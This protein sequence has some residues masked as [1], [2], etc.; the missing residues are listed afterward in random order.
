MASSPLQF[1]TAAADET[2][3]HCQVVRAASKAERE[4]MVKE[5]ARQSNGG[6]SKCHTLRHTNTT[7]RGRPNTCR[8]CDAIGHYA[9]KCPTWDPTKSTPSASGHC[10]FCFGKHFT[11]SDK[12]PV[13]H[14]VDPSDKRGKSAEPIGV[15]STS[16]GR[17]GL[18]PAQK[19]TMHHSG[20]PSKQKAGFTLTHSR[21]C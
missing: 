18:S 4:F 13:H 2:T 12:C 6:C 14:F 11:G 3:D 21:N 19:L 15:R 8:I 1:T 7:C 10:A 17:S 5:F 16:R 20:Y 9:D